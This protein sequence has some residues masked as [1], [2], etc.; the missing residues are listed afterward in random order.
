MLEKYKV[1]EA[2]FKN[3]NKMLQNKKEGLD[4]FDFIQTFEHNYSNNKHYFVSCH[5]I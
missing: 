4:T 5:I 3:L 2:L 1:V